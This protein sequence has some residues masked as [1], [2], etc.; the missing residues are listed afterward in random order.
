MSMDLV[1]SF[2]SWLIGAGDW[3]KPGKAPVP[4]GRQAHAGI[5]PAT[6][7]VVEQNYQEYLM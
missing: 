4:T 5:Q 6:L 1:F 2:R 7:V 3:K